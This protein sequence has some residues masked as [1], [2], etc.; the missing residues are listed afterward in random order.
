ME[1]DLSVRHRTGVED[2]VLLENY[3][4]EEAFIENLYKRYN[5][6]LIYTYIGSVLVSVN[7]YQVLPIYDQNYVETYRNANF[8]ELPP[9]IFAVTDTALKSLCGE[10]RDQ[11]ILISGESGAG[12][13]EASKKVLQY[14]AATSRQ[15]GKVETVKDK[16]LQSNPVLEAF[17]NAKTNRNDNSSRFG[18]YMDVEFNF[19]GDPI[20]G[21]IINYL[22]EKSRVVFQANGERNFHIFYQLLAG[23]DDSLLQKLSLERGPQLYSYLKQ[24]DSCKV[25]S[26]DDA[27]DFQNVKNALKVMEI[28][29][30]EQDAL[31]QLV[32]VVMHLGN[33]DFISDKNGHAVL[34]NPE[35][36]A[37]VAKL[38]GCP[39][40]MLSSALTQRTIEASGD[41]VKTPLNEIS[42]AK[43]RD[44]LAKSLYERLFSWLV[45]RLNRSLEAAHEKKKVVMGILDIYGFEIFENNSFEQLCINYCN[46]K[47][48]QL[49]IELTLRTEQDEYRREGIQWEPVTYFDNKI[50][51]D[52]VE[53]KRNKGII[54]ILDEECLR[55]GEANDLTFL[56]KMNSML[57]E[58]PHY[59]SH[60]KGDHKM[61]KTIERHQFRL[62]HYAGD[63][64]YSV[65]GFIEKNNDLLFRDLKETI[66]ASTNPIT[67]D[68]F[69]KAEMSSKKRPETAASQFKAS[70]ALLLKLLVSKE[71]SYIRCIKPNDF[72]LASNFDINVVA[73]QVKYLGLMENL[74][75]R[76]A[77]FAYRRL[78]EP[79]INRYKSLCPET[80][81]FPKGTPKEAVQTLVNHLNYGPDDY[82]MGA[83]KIFI[84]FPKT[85]F[86]TEDAFQK[87]KNR[88]AT[89][90][91]K[92][93]K[94]RL[95]RRQYLKMRTACICIQAY[96]RRFLAKRAAERRRWAT[97][98]VRTFI[99]GFIARNDPAS[100]ANA[101][102]TSFV[103]CQFLLRLVKKL[104]KSVLDKRWPEAPLICK[105]P[106]ELLRDLYMKTMVRRYCKG[107]SPPRRRQ[108]ELKVMA[109][110][111]FKGNRKSYPN[112]IAEW[113]VDSRLSAQAVPEFHSSFENIYKPLNEKILYSVPVVKFD[114]HGYKP[115]ERILCITNCALY[116]LDA[117][118]SKIKHRLTFNTITG[119]TVTNGMD[120]LILI[121]VPEDTA[122]D[123]GDIILEC[124]FLIETLTRMYEASG[125]NQEMI[126]FESK[127]SLTH[128]VVKGKPGIIEFSQAPG[129]GIAK[130]KNGHLIVAASS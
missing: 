94:G 51:C 104:P 115:R 34:K 23:A 21:H 112:S 22:L 66:I 102:F 71:P 107:L 38:A 78:Y 45:Q 98:V 65:H 50:I 73:H 19:L 43:A 95:Q 105:E 80:W 60:A 64:T 108:F 129:S 48:Q 128:N 85:F 88:L 113:F 124:R 3:T 18:K 2:F 12:K 9:H 5:E 122:T 20:G 61:Q 16:L 42:A 67:N 55:P 58:H 52:L 40:E 110:Q 7:P 33:V 32:A 11:C 114:R 83:T 46:E 90:I 91:Q 123:K 126:H 89:I 29:A 111:L 17:G 69:T 125:R 28:N 93:Y 106:N 44:A 70:L 27:S 97:V 4:S 36:V 57:A 76:R 99:K 14:I 103:R 30:D 37:T 72:K 120:N 63:V 92:V 56:S 96:A 41:V 81:P 39:L 47:L 25:D 74:R 118:D 127:S 13:T 62:K 86:E 8:Y 26:I 68:L 119:I 82:R 79:F 10:F 35:V 121:R 75:V 87:G 15:K 49:F 77:G 117:K 109:E 100:E 1:R 53:E 6:R 24:G 31:F 59:L 54:S 84:R 101:K 130:G 116:L